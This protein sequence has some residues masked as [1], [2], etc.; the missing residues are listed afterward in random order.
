M[1]GELSL[2]MLEMKTE[3]KINDADYFLQLEDLLQNKDIAQGQCLECH[4]NTTKMCQQCATV[5]CEQKG[6][7]NKC[8]IHTEKALDYYCKDCSKSICMDCLVVGGEKSCKNHN[9]VST[10][11]MNEELLEELA[12]ISPKVDETFR[13]LTK[14]AVDIGHLLLDIA[15]DT[16]SSDLTQIAS[17]VEQHFSKL[18]FIIQTQKKEII[19][20][21][22]FLKNAEKESLHKA[23]STLADSITKAK[24]VLMAINK[25]LSVDKIRQANMSI[26]LEDAKKVV[27]SPWYL[28]RIR[29]PRNLV[30]NEEV[31]N[32]ISGYIRLEGDNNSTY[33]LLSTAELDPS[34]EIPP[35]PPAPVYPP[36]LPKDVRQQNKPKSEKEPA[37]SQSFY[38][39]APTYRKSGSLSSINSLNSDSSFISSH[40]AINRDDGY[41]RPIIQ[42]V[43]PFPESQ[44]P[45]QLHEGGQELVY[46]SHIVTPH[47]FFVQRACHQTMVEEMLKEFRNAVS[48]PTPSVTHVVEGKFYLVFNKADSLW[49]RCRVIS[50]DRKNTSKPLFQVFCIDFGSTEIVP[51]DKLRLLP[52]AWVQSP[53]PFAINCSLANCEPMSGAWT[54]DDALFIQNITDNKQAVMHVHR[55]RSTSN[56]SVTIDCEVTTFEGGVS[57]AHALVFHGRARMPNPR[58]PYPRNKSIIEKPKLFISNN[59]FKLKTVEEVYITHIVSPD[60][61]YVRKQHL[62]EVYEKLSEELD[63]NYSVNTGTIYLPELEM[64]C[65]VN[66]EKYGAADAVGRGLRAKWARAVVRELPGRGR[67]R[68]LLPDCGA[69]VL[70]HWSALRRIQPAFTRLRALATECHLAGVTPINKKWSPNSVLLLQKF[71]NRPLELYVEDNRN[72]SLGVT[73][74]DKTDTENVICLNTEMVRCRFAVSFGLFM[75]NKQNVVEEPVITNK[76]PLEQN[77]PPPKRNPENVVNVLKKDQFPKTKGAEEHLKARDKGPLR[78]EAKVLYYQSPSLIYVSLV[79]QQKTFNSLYENIQKHYSKKKTQ[80]KEKWS[81]GDRCCT[82]CQQSQTWRRA[83]IVEL[84]SDS[85]KVFYSDFA[86][87]ETVPLSSLRELTEDFSSIGY[88]A[89]K[90]HL[91]GVV[92]ADGEEWPSVTKE[93]LKEMLDVYKRIFITKFG[94]FK[95][96]SMPVEMWVYHTTQGEALEANISE[97][98]CLNK[99]IIDQGLGIPDKNLK[100]SSPS[101]ATDNASGNML[102]FLNVTGSVEEW[103]QLEPLPTKPLILKS[104]S[105]SNSNASTPVNCTF[106]TGNDE[107][108]QTTKDEIETIFI[109]DWM[110]PEPFQNEE[111]MGVPTYVDYDGIIYLHDVSQRDTLDLIR[112]ALD[113]RFKKPD[114][115]AKYAKWAVVEFEMAEYSDGSKAVVRKYGPKK[116]TYDDPKNSPLLESDSGPD[117]LVEEEEEKDTDLSA[118]YDCYD[119][120]LLKGRDW[121]KIVQEDEEKKSFEGKYFNFKTNIVKE[122]VCNIT[123]IN[124]VNN[125]QLNIVHCEETMGKYEEMFKKLQETANSMA[126]LNGIFENKACVAMFT[127]DGQWYRASILEYSENTNQLKVRYVDYGNIE[128]ICLADVRE[129]EEEFIDLPPLTVQ[130]ILYAIEINPIADVKVLTTE[131]EQTFLDK[132]PFHANVIDYKDGVPCVELKNEQ[133]ELV[134]QNL[135]A[136]KIFLRSHTL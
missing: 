91:C 61:F 109:S 44:H 41:Q 119:M 40:N 21:I 133:G 111:F 123:V 25:S 8:N 108:T 59:D 120:K 99:K 18:T 93:Y 68:L 1:L 122:F 9:L 110:P 67:V 26:L 80:G 116:S 27:G 2:E 107:K 102:S 28:N 97:W 19:D 134:Y 103:L 5:I 42:S 94:E 14:T 16:G 121:N 38:K 81:I 36:E 77:A 70:A 58:L 50:I 88:A 64:V 127:E 105:E 101:V 60:N 32:L 52:P 47:N 104:D 24:S 17:E 11:E 33:E 39:R 130:A 98:R 125:F 73:L 30:V 46:I 128:I 51:L 72:R 6:L 113:V 4:N 85:A 55:I 76:S 7:I 23:K 100:T 13:R 22:L 96:K 75:F 66:V 56:Y 45:K 62:Q 35:A 118:S 78:L 29:I 126:P 136:N 69:S 15:N 115:K 74:Y 43:S 49:Q 106:N 82:I 20:K 124:D 71:S 54:T 48:L 63:Q 117:Y 83:V 65:V 90:C 53:F 10:Q 131:Y 89:I 129:I 92:P 31:C 37:K 87:I 12:E 34:I 95:D 112:K 135:I 57:L 132:G 84:A 86:C 79:H 3:E 114:P